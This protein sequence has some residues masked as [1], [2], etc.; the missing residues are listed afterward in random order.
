MVIQPSSVISGC[1]FMLL[2]CW[3]TQ[4][5][6]ATITVTVDRD[7]IHI[8]ESFTITFK[9]DAAVGDDPNF[10]I[11]EKNFNILH[12]NHSTNVS[13]MNG[14]LSNTRVW[15]LVLMPKALGEITIPSIAF[16]K[17]VSVPFHVTIVERKS[18][19]SA[20]GPE[21]LF[22][23][24]NAHPRQ[25]FVQEQIIFTV[26]FYRSIVI[27]NGTI[28][29]PTLSDGDAVVKKLGENKTFQTRRDGVDYH[30][31]ELRY[32]LFPQKSGSLVVNPVVFEGTSVAQSRSFFSPGNAQRRRLRSDE[33]TLQVNPIPSS[34][35]GSTWLPSPNLQLSEMWPQ[36]PP[37]F[38]VGEPVTRTLLLEVEGLTAAQLPEIN[39]EVP[40]TLKEYPDQP[41]QKDNVSL[42]GVTGIRQEKVALIPSEVG[43]LT[44]PSVEVPWWNTL[45][46]TIEVARL[47]ERS[48][49]VEAAI[50]KQRFDESFEVP[51]SVE[52]ASSPSK[53]I[54]VQSSWPGKSFWLLLTGV[55]TMGWLI[56]A[57][58]LWRERYGVRSVQVH[59]QDTAT[60]SKR[61]I[62]K[63]FRYACEN[64]DVEAAKLSLVVWASLEWS[65]DV[66]KTIGAIAERFSGTLR[67]ELDR[68]NK[69]LYG[70]APEKWDGQA[71]W[72]AFEHSKSKGAISPNTPGERLEPLWVTS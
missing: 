9:A 42:Q 57:L 58:F 44:L 32:A 72:S 65:G 34:F 4:G 25:S 14:T 27:E 52:V 19:Q 61:A 70:Q 20:T 67:E 37:R 62:E 49:L 2:M 13:F 48:V 15:T 1:F 21:D 71:L 46:N 29:E 23:E 40:S 59:D 53:S 47:P 35:Y 17:D 30:V 7:P 38:M 60:K 68:L 24:V 11:L 45:T 43:H 6:A 51:Q 12:K 33:I 5:F 31:V 8:D 28:T 66:P 54:R 69:V 63:Q 64:G 56:T 55:L 16:G 26:R 50:K 36:T 18:T 10:S 41:M 22:L 3:L 39:K